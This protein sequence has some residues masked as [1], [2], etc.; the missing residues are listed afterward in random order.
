MTKGK[1]LSDLFD[2]EPH[3]WGLRGDPYLWAAMKDYFC[4]T[5]LPSTSDEVSIQVSQAF[6]A[7]TGRPIEVQ[8]HF[9]VEK[10]AHGGMSTGYIDPGWW[11][12]KG[13]QVLAQAFQRLQRGATPAIG[14]R[15][16]L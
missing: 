14:T 2:V 12:G 6:E 3:T 4:N 8:A 5:P 15:S 11:R 9:Q 7:L 13:Q 1:H 16:D 10:F